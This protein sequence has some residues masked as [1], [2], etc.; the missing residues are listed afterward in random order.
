[1]IIIAHFAVEVETIPRSGII[2]GSKNIYYGDLVDENC[3]F[4]SL[5]E[6]K[7]LYEK[8]RNIFFILFH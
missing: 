3:S 1:M 2:P 5:P 8:S 6:I 7:E 4:K